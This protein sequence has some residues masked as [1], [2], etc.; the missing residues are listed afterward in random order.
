LAGGCAPQTGEINGQT[1]TMKTASAMRMG[2]AFLPIRGGAI[3]DL[4]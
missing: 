1:A 4:R 2:G 3:E